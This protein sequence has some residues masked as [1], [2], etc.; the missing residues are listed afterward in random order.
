MGAKQVKGYTPQVPQQANEFDCGIFMLHFLE[1]FMKTAPTLED[2]LSDEGARL[3]FFDKPGW[4]TLKEIRRKRD[5]LRDL[6]DS[7]RASPQIQTNVQIQSDIF[8]GSS[9]NRAVSQKRQRRGTDLIVVADKDDTKQTSITI[10]ED[11]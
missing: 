4:C 2:L 8:S 10:A 7:L 1:L 11:G 6:I 9:L 5:Q 3:H